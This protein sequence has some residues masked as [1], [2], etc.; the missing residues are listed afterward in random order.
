MRQCPWGHWAAAIHNSM[1][2][3]W[4]W[5]GTFDI[6]EEA[7]FMYDSSVVRLKGAKVV[8]NFPRESIAKPHPS[9]KGGSHQQGAEQE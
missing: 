9:G 6:M 2:R 4:V 3:K 5:L 1:Q 8:T 7:A